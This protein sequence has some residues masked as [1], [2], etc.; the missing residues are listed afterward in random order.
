MTDI[1]GDN[2]GENISLS[3]DFDGDGINDNVSVCHDKNNNKYIFVF[4]GKIYFVSERY[5]Y[6]PWDANISTIRYSNGELTIS[7]CFGN[8]RFCKTLTLKYFEY[9]KNMRLVNYKEEYFGDA[10]NRGAYV[11]TV[12]F[13]SE[14]YNIGGATKTF[15]IKYAITLSDIETYFDSL[16][17]LGE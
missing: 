4:I 3:A 2:Q 12:D 16:E 13:L 10:A 8:N 1:P 5:W 17:K 9:L 6:F 7:S 14:T 15:T 11:K